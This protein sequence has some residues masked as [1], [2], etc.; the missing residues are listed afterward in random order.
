MVP[1]TGHTGLNVWVPVADETTAVT[2]LRDS[3]YAVSPGSVNRLRS[4]PGIRVTVSP[5]LGDD[6]LERIADTIAALATPSPSTSR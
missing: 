3:G 1:A 6:D 4:A 2:A 5:L